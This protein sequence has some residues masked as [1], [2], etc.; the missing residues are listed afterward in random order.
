MSSSCE[1][2]LFA[3]FG[4]SSAIKLTVSG[5]MGTKASVIT[6]E[7]IKTDGFNISAY[8]TDT[9]KR[10]VIGNSPDIPAGI[11]V[12]A[13]PYQGP[14]DEGTYPD[15]VYKLKDIHVSYDSSRGSEPW[16][17]AGNEDYANPKFSWV[18]GVA[19]N[20]FSY[21][22][23]SADGRTIT[24]EDDSADDR[25]PFSYTAPTT[26]GVVCPSDCADLI[27]AFTQHTATF[28]SDQ[29]NPNYGKLKSGS[30]STIDIKFHHALAQIRFCLSTDDD[31]FNPSYE[32]VSVRLKDINRQGEC[33]FIGSSS[34]FSWPDTALDKPT[35]YFQTF[36]ASFL[37]GTAPSGWTSGSYNSGAYNLFTNTADVLFVIPQSLSECRVSVT[38]RQGGSTTTLTGRL[39]A[40]TDLSPNV[41]WEAGKYYT[42]KIGT[43]GKGDSIALNMTL[44]DW[45]ERENYIPIG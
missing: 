39:P 29:T 38:L 1:K 12:D 33:T 7:S 28:E 44:V 36:N 37:S 42:Y 14:Y 10:D 23:A 26:D 27:F 4:D 13:G 18:N 8:V 15:D 5:V 35:D 20:F 11:F 30:K 21:A 43:T 16:R 41:S 19:M 45:A 22:P 31:T 9:W 25:Y 40:T 17:I 3:G 34:T 32:L 6:T 24:K 2:G